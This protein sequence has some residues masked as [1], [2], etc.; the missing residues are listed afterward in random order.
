[1]KGSA[2]TDMNI[3]KQLITSIYSPKT[4]ATF[5]FQGIGK[6]ILYV[7]LLSLLATLPIAIQLQNTLKNGIDDFENIL[8]DELP[9]FSIKNGTLLSDEQNPIEIRTDQFIIVF[10]PSDT[11]SDSDIEKKGDAIAFLKKK[12]VFISNGIPQSFDYKMLNRDLTKAAILDFMKQIDHIVPIFIPILLVI[13]YL[14]NS[15]TKF[16]E[17]TILALFGLFY[18][19]NMNRTLNFKQVWIISAYSTTMATIFFTLMNAFQ[20]I[21]PFAFVINWFVCLI[22]LHLVIKEIPPTTSKTA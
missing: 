22:I 2:D 11:Y 12:F 13:M 15:V 21:V 3:F 14:F 20:L 7:F 17:I 10:D 4:I 8:R 16:I 5:Q 18:K 9:D 19:N 1:M 6:A